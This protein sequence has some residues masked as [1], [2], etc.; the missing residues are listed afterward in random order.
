[1]RNIRPRRQFSMG[2]RSPCR[3]LL[4]GKVTEPARYVC[5]LVRASQKR[6]EDHPN[7]MR[8]AR[9]M[10]STCSCIRRRKDKINLPNILLRELS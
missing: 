7:H 9:L 8:L 1:V 6:N 2:S 4:F 5:G 3:E 10:A